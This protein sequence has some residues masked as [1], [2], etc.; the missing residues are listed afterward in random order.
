MS[1]RLSCFL[2]GIIFLTG[3]EGKPVANPALTQRINHYL[4][5]IDAQ[6][7]Y[8]NT[9]E[10][11]VNNDKNLKQYKNETM[12]FFNKFFTFQSLR[13]QI[14]QLYSEFYTLADIN[15]L[16]KFYSTPLGKKHVKAEIKLES[17][18]EELVDEKLVKMMP[19]IAKWFQETFKIDVSENDLNK[20]L[21]SD[22]DD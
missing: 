15:G 4:N 21:N 1:V 20:D 17:R 19:Q 7:E 11:Y 10:T 6:K 12:T 16:I 22:D 13:P 5:V 8:E 2:F 3:I 9:L 18:M 14:V